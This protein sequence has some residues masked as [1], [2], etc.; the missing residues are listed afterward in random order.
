MHVTYKPSD[1]NPYELHIIYIHRNANLDNLWVQVGALGSASEK[2]LEV[3][4]FIIHPKCDFGFDYS[5]SVVRLKTELEYN[6]DVAP[7]CLSHAA[8]SS[9]SLCFTMGYNDTGRCLTIV[10]IMNE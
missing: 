4:S 2:T 7:V 6:Q 1:F 8:R 9:D 5:I 10:D 3:D